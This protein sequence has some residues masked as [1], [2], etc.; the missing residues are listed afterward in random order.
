MLR[1][2]ELKAMAKKNRGSQQSHSKAAV[3][4]AA[5]ALAARSEYRAPV[6]ALFSFGEVEWKKKWPDYGALG[7]G[8]SDV[9]ELSRMA[10]DY[11]LD[12]AESPLVGGAPIH[13]M[14]ILARRGNPDVLPA[15]L[16]SLA[17]RDDYDFLREEMAEIISTIGVAAIPAVQEFYAL[18]EESPYD[19]A[20]LADGLVEIAKKDR[21]AHARVVEVLTGE[22]SRYQENSLLWNGFLMASLIDLAAGETLPL[23]E[24]VFAA[25]AVD[26]FICGDLRDVRAEF[27]LVPT[28]RDTGPLFLTDTRAKLPNFLLNLP[29]QPKKK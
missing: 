26:E 21:A 10:S 14:R 1:S 4:W 5:P 25:D 7:F 29:P 6:D 13:A 20:S 17:E 3:N 9:P 24:K 27:G 22:L 2:I 19:R 16:A 12:F 23:I 28:Q 11:R 15:L 8:E 18:P